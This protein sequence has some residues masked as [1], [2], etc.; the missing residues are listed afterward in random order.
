MIVEVGKRVVSLICGQNYSSFSSVVSQSLDLAYWVLFSCVCA[1]MHCNWAPV[2][3]LFTVHREIAV[4]FDS[5]YVVE[6]MVDAEKSFSY[7]VLCE[8]DL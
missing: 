2:G 4:F 6:G 1:C 8:N 7:S 3:E 5:Y